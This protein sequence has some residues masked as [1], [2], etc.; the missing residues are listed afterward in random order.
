MR[1]EWARTRK[2]GELDSRRSPVEYLWVCS[3]GT[4]SWSHEWDTGAMN[5]VLHPPLT[6]FHANHQHYFIG[7]FCTFV[8]LKQVWS[9][10][11][12][13]G[14]QF[15]YSHS[16][17]FIRDQRSERLEG[18]N[19]PDRIER[20]RERERNIGRCED[21]SLVKSQSG[22]CQYVQLKK[23]TTFQGYD[24]NGKFVQVVIMTDIRQVF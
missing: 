16:L 17:H 21:R 14:W 10:T 20:K 4:Y 12:R 11:S 1:C 5:N 2:V 7:W 6:P 23:L 9:R 22:Q 15:S 8:S 19:C 24:P 18:K 3:W 13:A